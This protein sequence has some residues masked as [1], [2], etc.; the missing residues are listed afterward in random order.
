[1][2][3]RLIFIIPTH[4][5]YLDVAKIAEQL[6]VKYWDNCPYPVIVSTNKIDKNPFSVFKV[7]ENS[8]SDEFVRRIYNAAME[9]EADYYLIIN[10]DRFLNEEIENNQLEAVLKYMDQHKIDFCRFIPGSRSNKTKLKFSKISKA[11]PYGYNLAGC[12]CTLQYIQDNMSENINGWV[13]E[14]Q[15]L[16]DTLLYEKDEYFENSVKLN[17]DILHSVHGIRKNQWIPKSY[18][19]ICQNNPEIDFS[20]RGV[21]EN[22]L[23]YILRDSLSG[24]MKKI[25]PR[26][27]KKI[28]I[29]LGRVGFKFTT[30]N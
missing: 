27:R 17:V 11:E 19:I 15:K 13:Y 20:I 9:F 25:S 30:K 5:S 29:I 3:N 2:K 14:N 8:D 26:T 28:K 6:F 22:S 10:E 24:V 18:K 4:S 16:E 7:M 21:A 12:I 23:G 1:M